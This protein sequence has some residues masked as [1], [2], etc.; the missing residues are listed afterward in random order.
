M[1]SASRTTTLL[2]SLGKISERLATN[3]TA[4]DVHLLR[5]TVRRIEALLAATLH[6]GDDRTRKPRKQLAKLRRRA[7]AVRDLDVQ[8][9]ALQGLRSDATTAEKRQALRFLR[10][11][12][13]EAAERLSR[14]VEKALADDLRKHLRRLAEELATVDAAGAATQRP[15]DPDRDWLAVAL[16]EFAARSVQWGEK[17][18]EESLHALRLACKRMRYTA[19]IAEQ[20]P[21]TRDAVA[22]FKRMQ[23]AMGD[24]H[25]WQTLARTVDQVLPGNEGAALRALVRARAKSKYLAAVRTVSDSRAR[26]LAMRERPRIRKAPTAVQRTGPAASSESAAGA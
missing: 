23:D 14:A 1:A 25:D 11:E 2:R 26:L 10:E 22:E 18:S 4:A 5:T 17:P 3:V 9:G 7:G 21:L 20:N 6:E 8:I 15:A 12:R 19:E 13:S 24:W 16:D